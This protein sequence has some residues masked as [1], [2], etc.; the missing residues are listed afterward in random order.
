M[1]AQMFRSCGLALILALIPL[2]SGCDQQRADSAPVTNVLTSQP[3]ANAIAANSD[4][5]QDT[6][7]PDSA[8][9]EEQLDDAPGNIISTPD[10]GS[11][12][13]SNNPRLTDFVKLVQAGMGDSVLMAYVTNS[14]TPFNVSSDDI[15]YLNDLGTPE[16]VV[17][18]MLQQDQYFNANSA[19]AAAAPQT[20]SA[21][22]NP[23][24][25]PEPGYPEQNAAVQPQESVPPLT[26]S[27]DVEAEVQQAPNVSYSYFYNSLSPYGSWVNIEGYGPCWQPT[28]V[29]ANPGWQPY[30]DRGHWDYTDCGWCWVSDYSWGW[31]PFHY[32]RWF[33]HNRRGWCWAPDTLWGPAWV[34]WRYNDAYC[35]WAPLPPAACY[36]PG[37]GFTYYGRSVGFDFG[38]GLAERHFVFVP[39]GHFH[40]RSPSHFRL[41]HREITKV[42]NTTTV[43]NQII[44][45]GN[46]L[47]NRGVP[48]DRVAAATHTQIHPIHV[49]PQAESPRAPQLGQ[50][51]R[52]LSVYRPALPA[53]RPAHNPKFVGEG[54]QPDPN[55]NLHARAERPPVTRN[56]TT[57]NPAMRNPAM[58]DQPASRPIISRPTPTMPTQGAGRDNRFS[59]PGAERPGSLILHRPDGTSGDGNQNPVRTGPPALRHG[60][61]FQPQAPA[62]PTVPAENNRRT[63]A[64]PVQPQQPIQSAPRQNL[65]PPSFNRPGVEQRGNGS[66]PQ[67]QPVAPTPRQ[68]AP[69]RVFEAPRA[70]PQVN[71]QNS[72]FRAEPPMRSQPAF[73]QE[74]VAPAAQPRAFES[75]PAPEVRSAPQY[76]APHQENSQGR[77]GGNSGGGNANG[78]GRNR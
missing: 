40:D 71:E 34:S 48:V 1:K 62:Q 38:F 77:G 22:P 74:P 6:N 10:V 60:P 14:P 42:Y 23:A 19:T 46:N 15:L 32:G 68:E 57:G 29:I 39:L 55:F 30:C 25:A 17:T 33:H 54:V 61:V 50:D 53:P 9:T 27:P 37:F 65:A 18:A 20:Q 44:R 73:R 24:P 4:Q 5:D 58:P 59:Q 56:L 66:F 28:A 47:I 41:P 8:L 69:P 2:F 11:T 63:F 49:R 52:S 64:P 26:P 72:G 51:G 21:Y 43:H 16:T 45:G 7:R 75:R 3:P 76:S 78:N 36:R 31:A 35:G 12:N 70:T 13:T 67:Q